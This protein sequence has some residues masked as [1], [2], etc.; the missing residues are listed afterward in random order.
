MIKKLSILFLIHISLLFLSQTKPPESYSLIRGVNEGVNMNRG[1]VDLN[2]PLF[3][4]IEGG[5]RLNNSLNYES[6]G[7]VPYLYPS[8]VGLN[9]NLNQF[10]KITRE[11]RK[12][13]LTTTTKKILNP[14]YGASPA[15]I[16]LANYSSYQYNDIRS[17]DRNDCIKTAYSNNAKKISIFNDALNPAYHATNLFGDTQQYYGQSINYEP[18]K[19]YFDFLGIKGYFIVDNEMN[20]IVFS[21][22]SSL[23]VDISKVDCYDIFGNIPFSQFIITDNKGN[24]YYFGGNTDAMDINFSYNRVTY[25]HHESNDPSHPTQIPYSYAKFNKTNYIDSWLLNKIVLANGSEIKAYY[26]QNNLTILNNY[27][28]NCCN[29]GGEYP[30]PMIENFSVYYVTDNTGFPSKQELL[31]NNLSIK[32]SRVVGMS[33]VDTYTKMAV[34]DSIKINDVTISYKYHN[35]LNPL[36]ITNNYL[37][38]IL[39]KRNNKQIKKVNLIYEDLGLT[40]KRTFLKQIL[41]STDENVN[42]DYYNTD[43]F[44]EYKNSTVMTYIGGIWNGSNS[45]F[46]DP[47]LDE[48][49]NSYDTGLLKKVTYPTK[50]STTYLYEFGDY[51]KIIGYHGVLNTNELSV[52]DYSGTINSPKLKKKIEKNSFNDSIVTRYEYLNDSGLSSG[53]LESGNLY[54]FVSIT[55]DSQAKLKGPVSTNK[56]S[57]LQYSTVKITTEGKGSRKIYFNDYITNP[58]TLTVKNFS[59]NNSSSPKEYLSKSYERGKISKEELYDNGNNLIK[60]TEYKYKNFLKKLPNLDA[61]NSTACDGCKVSDLNY[62]ITVRQPGP[63]ESITSKYVPIIPYLLSSETTTEYFGGKTIQTKRNISYMDKINYGGLNNLW[64]P[65]PVEEK[66]TTAAGTATKK[67]LYPNELIK[68]NCSGF[69]NCPNSENAT[70]S[71]WGNYKSMLDSNILIPL[72][73]ITKNTDNKFYLRENL[74]TAS[75]TFLYAPKKVRHSLLNVPLDFDN[76]TIPTTNTVDDITYDVYDEKANNL[77]YT[78]KDGIPV[79]TIYGYNQ[80][81]PIVTITGITYEQLMQIFGLPNTPT[82]YLSLDIVAKSN[83]DKDSASEQLLLNALETFRNNPA[84]ANYQVSTSTYDPLIG[85]KSITPPSGLRENYIYDSANRL[86]KVTDVNG[87]IL[88]EHTYNYKH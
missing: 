33:Q 6:R 9:W 76:Y 58:D 68:G 57:I 46:Y 86:Q 42:L 30:M 16:Y 40:N 80:S 87:N 63:F 55:N 15:H 45:I 75:N 67:Y 71:Q 44:P 25:D 11:S 56:S 38:E 77:Q 1:M 21:E 39:V 22:N 73:E 64:H 65:F 34:L 53:I 85:V 43:D 31:Q 50:G 29:T 27:R 60:K 81:L 49:K 17:Y 19:Y 59:G 14:F 32:H 18:D 26:K 5:F 36:E 62:Y 84:L 51:S 23:K 48:Y 74:F 52:I 2:I 4:I 12:I 82:G 10:G 47:T 61:V 72:V 79:T 8:F 24:K 7:F 69:R 37:D 66:I 13:D 28:G 41:S 83:A 70:A 78:P 35:T 3:D 88:K 54:S 20:P